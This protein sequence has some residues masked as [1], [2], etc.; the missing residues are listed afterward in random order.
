MIRA[1]GY[2]SDRF[3]PFDPGRLC[4]GRERWIEPFE[5]EGN[6]AALTLSRLVITGAAF[7]DDSAEDAHRGLPH[8]G[9]DLAALIGLLFPRRPL[10]AFMEDGHPA[11]IPEH[12]EGVEAY[13]GY[14][15]GGAVSVGLIRWHQ[16]VNGIAE[17]REILGDPPDAER[18]R[19]F[20]VLPEGADD[21]R[22]E[23]ALDPVFLLVG[24]STLDSPPARYQP[25]ALP[26][27]LEHAEAVILLHRDK[28]GPALGIYTR[29]PG[30]A[31]SRLEAWA[32]KEGTLLVPFA[33]PPMLARW[34]RAIAELREHWLETRKDEFPV[35]P[36]PEPTHWRGRGADRP[37]E[38]D[39]A[40]A[41]E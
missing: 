3:S 30:K 19:G 38:T 2:S 18:V 33:I 9:V 37:P 1:L 15:A 14:R 29:E 16:R 4:R 22:A 8:G 32:A 39:A 10:L 34:D 6:E 36:A 7:T 28:H 20:L 17:L 23:A 41:E 40:P 12:A 25:A 5:P 27:V 21:A 13:E 24:M 35:P 26:E 31:A 11:D